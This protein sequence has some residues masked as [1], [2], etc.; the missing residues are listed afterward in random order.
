MTLNKW[1]KLKEKLIT[2]NKYYIYVISI[3]IEYLQNLH[4][5]Q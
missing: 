1:K 2:G 4:I 3:I 5:K